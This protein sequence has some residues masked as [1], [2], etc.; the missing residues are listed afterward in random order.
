MM[1]LLMMVGMTKLIMMNKNIEININLKICF[2]VFNNSS[3]MDIDPETRDKIKQQI[4]EIFKDKTNIN[5][6][7]ENSIYH[8][9]LE[10]ATEQDTPYL[11]GQIYEDK[12][13][14]IVCQLSNK[15]IVNS[16]KSGIINDKKI[17]IKKIAYMT[18][19]ELDPDKNNDIKKKREMEEY[20]KN[21]KTGTS[22]FT[23]SK[24]KKSNCSVTQKQVRAGDEPPTTFVSCLECGHSFKF[25]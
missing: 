9:A 3:I 2:I 4:F 14:Q 21:N 24:C 10:Y 19:E 23:C 6:D 25:N 13:H 5:K 7:I 20:K 12:A 15:K 1:K 17:D 11:V 8:Y 18:P 16:I 22:A